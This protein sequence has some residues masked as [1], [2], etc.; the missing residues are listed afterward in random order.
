MKLRTAIRI[1]VFLLTAHQCFA[2]EAETQLEVGKISSWRQ[3]Q[4]QINGQADFGFYGQSRPSGRSGYNGF[5]SPN[6]W[7][8]ARAQRSS[9]W[10][11][12]FA[13]KTTSVRESNSQSYLLRPDLAI[14]QGPVLENVQLQ[15]GLMESPL[16]SHL[17]YWQTWN[18][19]GSYFEYPLIQLGYVSERDLGTKFEG[20]IDE[21]SRWVFSI[22]NGEGLK[23]DEKGRGKDWLLLYDY[24]QKTASIPLR[25]QVFYGEGNYENIDPAVSARH[26]AGLG[27][28]YDNPGDGGWLW[29][30][31]WQTKDA[32]DGALGK[33]ADAVD[34]AL[35]GGQEVTGLGYGIWLKYPVILKTHEL[36][37]QWY[38]FDADQGEEGRGLS[39]VG[40]GWLWHQ[41]EELT[42]AFLYS[43]RDYQ[44]PYAAVAQEQTLGQIRVKFEF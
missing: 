43:S 21:F 39:T 23:S 5:E 26:R 34:L 22:T 40:A 38:E 7:L 33:I 9:P 37:A 30:Q 3:M 27:F 24:H 28:G 14:I 42:W 12:Q 6:I 20:Q 11:F 8:K 25:F 41:R 13:I 10:S 36:I 15:M 32:V 29:L 1:L 19:L 31:A 18:W 4:W 16:L 35:K 2:Q 17:G 44:T